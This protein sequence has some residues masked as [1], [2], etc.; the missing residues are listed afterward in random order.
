MR[1]VLC[2]WLMMQKKA[3]VQPLN[4]TRDVALCPLVPYVVKAVMVLARLCRCTGYPGPSLL[5]S[6]MSRDMTKTTKW[7]CPQRRQISLGIH[8][9]WSVSPLCA[10]WVA[11]DPRFLHAD[12]ED[13]D[14]TGWMPRLIWVFAGRTL[15]LLVLSCDYHCHMSK[16]CIMIRYLFFL[17]LSFNDH[18]Q[19][20]CLHFDSYE[21]LRFHLSL[22]LATS[23]EP[24]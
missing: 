8:P 18:F 22:H 7:V 21:A 17:F 4:R 5:P 3:H 24:Y 9:V 14:Q 16:F 12:S 15:I 1:G 19:Y 6:D 13:S 2:M 11:K 10:Q 20:T 23:G